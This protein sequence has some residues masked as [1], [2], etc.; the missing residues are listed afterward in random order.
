MVEFALL[1]LDTAPIGWRIW[2]LS[3]E[4]W[5]RSQPVPQPTPATG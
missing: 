1:L 2:T 4:G 3:D 5:E